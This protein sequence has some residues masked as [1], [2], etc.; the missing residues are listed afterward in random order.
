MNNLMCK[1]CKNKNYFFYFHQ[2]LAKLETVKTNHYNFVNLIKR[3]NHGLSRNFYA[4][5]DYKTGDN[6]EKFSYKY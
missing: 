5:Y 4:I 2:L 3:K 1:K 6:V